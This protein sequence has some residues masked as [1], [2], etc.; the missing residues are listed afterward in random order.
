MPSLQITLPTVLGDLEI[1]A[2]PSRLAKAEKL[3]KTTPELLTKAYEVAG[4][5]YAN[6]I[7]KMAK[8]CLTHGIPPRGSGVSWPPH[9]SLTVKRL[10]QHTLLLWTGQYRNYIRVLRRGT[11]IA[12]GVPPGMKKYRRDDYKDPNPLTLSQVAKILEYG[13]LDGKIPE[14]P[15]WRY[16]WPTVGGKESY[17]K[18]LA[19]QIRKQI[20]NFR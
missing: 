20:R 10:G 17:K 1:Y 3:L 12:V 11:R 4:T 16:L 14:R 6:R 9:T 13:T 15:L 18:E 2:N 8:Y 7:M 19:Y 5:I